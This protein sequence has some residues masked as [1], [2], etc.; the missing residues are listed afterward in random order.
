M[1][2]V[3]FIFLLFFVSYTAS[4]K[5]F[6]RPNPSKVIIIQLNKSKSSPF[7]LVGTKEEESESDNPKDKTE[8]EALSK[9]LVSFMLYSD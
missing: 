7:A 2:N 3:L 9:K 1:K 6:L 8:Y 5:N 4:M